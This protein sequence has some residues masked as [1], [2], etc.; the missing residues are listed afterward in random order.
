MAVCCCC[1]GNGQDVLT[2]CGMPTVQEVNEK[3]E[4]DSEDV[5]R[6][7]KSSSGIVGSG[8]SQNGN[9]DWNNRGRT[10]EHFPFSI[11][12]DIKYNTQVGQK[13]LYL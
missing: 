9:T 13:Y 8:T 12:Y 2:S 7:E 10:Q 6:G 5:R 4:A 1:R 3:A 11:H